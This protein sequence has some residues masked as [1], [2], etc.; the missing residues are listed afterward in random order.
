MLTVTEPSG[1]TQICAVSGLTEVYGPPAT[2]IALAMPRPRSLRRVRASA[3]RFSK[4][5]CVGDRQRHVHAAREVAAV[6]GEHEPRLERHRGGRDQVPAPQLDRIDAELVRGDVD[7][8]LDR[9]RR[10]GP[11]GAPIGPGG[12]GVGEHA[13]GLM[14]MA[15]VVY[16]PATPPMLLVP[17]PALR[18]VRYAPTL[19]VDRHA[20]RQELPV[21]IERQLRGGDVVAAVLVGD[22]PF[23]AVRRPL[24]RPP[25]PARGPQ[26]E[27]H[28]GIERR[29]ACRSCRRPRR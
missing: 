10:L 11:A 13:G 5:A 24:H 14:W 3:R 28:L 15:G 23:A 21:P 25:Q 29:C 16:T 12:R 6:V 8:A 19:S 18:W 1:F 7:H 26:H 9:E 2:S 22:E 4:L 20:Q 17:G 27:D